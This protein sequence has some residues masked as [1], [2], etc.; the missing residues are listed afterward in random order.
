VVGG[1]RIHA[2]AAAYLARSLPSAEVARDEARAASA[3][4]TFELLT[5]LPGRHRIVELD[6]EPTRV[7]LP[8]PG[9]ALEKR[10]ATLGE[11]ERV[12]QHPEMVV[13]TVRPRVEDAGSTKLL[14]GT[15]RPFATIRYV[16]ACTAS[17][18]SRAHISGKPLNEY[19]FVAG[20]ASISSAS[21]DAVTEIASGPVIQ[22]L[23]AEIDGSANTCT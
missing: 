3:P 15:R 10:I 7:A 9:S 16:L 5:T 23:P 8:A 17:H 22:S 18:T 19:S 12:L 13:G 4:P 1:A 20:S 14:T 2:S 6:V 21:C 11:R